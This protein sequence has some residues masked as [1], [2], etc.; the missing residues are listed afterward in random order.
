MGATKADLEVPLN[1][2][3]TDAIDKYKVAVKPFVEYRAEFYAQ[4]RRGLKCSRLHFS[5]CIRGHR[6]GRMRMTCGKR[7]IRT[8]GRGR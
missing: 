7:W 3:L 8:F 2:E 5:I 1:K 4:L 6:T